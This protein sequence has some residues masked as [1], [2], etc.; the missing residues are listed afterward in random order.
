MCLLLDQY[1]VGDWNANQSWRM[2]Y[3]NT[4]IWDATAQK[5]QLLHPLHD[6]LAAVI[7][8]SRI[9][10][11]LELLLKFAW[12]PSNYAVA[13]SVVLTGSV[14]SPAPCCNNLRIVCPSTADPWPGGTPI[15]P[16]HYPSMCSDGTPITPRHYPAA[17][18]PFA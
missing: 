11:L 14:P 4:C 2:W 5:S 1:V 7:M 3:I 9:K 10:W 15:T 8:H 13:R 18:T 12:I 6:R 16:R 17:L